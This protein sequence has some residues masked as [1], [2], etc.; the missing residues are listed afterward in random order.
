MKII[1]HGKLREWSLQATCEKCTAILRLEQPEDLFKKWV[2]TEYHG[3]R[4]IEGEMRYF[5]KCPE[6]HH[7][8]RVDWKDINED[9]REAIRKI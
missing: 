9:V 4:P 1:K 5:Y 3:A 6:C 8:N 7:R 2:V